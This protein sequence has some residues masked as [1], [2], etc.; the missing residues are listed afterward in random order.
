MYKTITKSFN[1]DWLHRFVFMG[2][3]KST[4]VHFQRKQKRSLHPKI[5]I[6]VWLTFSK[7]NIER[8]IFLLTG[9]SDG[10]A[11]GLLRVVHFIT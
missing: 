10:I 8:N 3:L 4:D 5:S 7:K 1:N 2:S 9:L 11:N 6:V